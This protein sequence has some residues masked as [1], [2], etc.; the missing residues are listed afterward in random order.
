M[1]TLKLTDINGR[2]IHF[3]ISSQTV[4]Q[5]EQASPSQ[6]WHGIRSNVK[7]GDGKWVEVRE[8]QDDVA[9]QLGAMG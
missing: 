8:T 1:K 2:S 9:A 5:C 6:C 4:A 3:H 7:V